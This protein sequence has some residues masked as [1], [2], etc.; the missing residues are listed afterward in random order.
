MLYYVLSKWTTSLVFV[1]FGGI[2][3]AEFIQDCGDATNYKNVDVVRMNNES[4]D[5][6]LNQD[7]S[8]QDL[9]LKAPLYISHPKNNETANPLH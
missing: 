9:V 1:L 7:Y 3:L 8:Q 5:Y 4:I 6:T 2:F